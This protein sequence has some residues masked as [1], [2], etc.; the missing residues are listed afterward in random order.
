[1]ALRCGIVG[2][3]N[4]GKSTLFNCISSGKAQSANF[5]FCTIEPNIGSTIVP[6]DRLEVLEKIVKPNR[7]VPAT[8][9]IVDIAGLVK[10]ASK[11]EGLGNQFLAN[12][13][14]T[15]AILHVLRC[16][17]D[18]N[19]V[20]VDGKI[21]PASDIDTIN[22]ELL[23]SDMELLERR[24]QKTAKMAKADKQMQGE[25]DLLNRLNEFLGE[26][27]N[28]RAME[29]D[30]E[31]AAFVKSLDLLSYKPII[32]VA[33]V[34]DEDLVAGGDN[35]FVQQ[36]REIAAA[37]DAEVVVIS[38]EIESEVAEL[39]D[40]EKA[41]FLEELGI[42]ES[43]LD[44]LIAA[45][46]RTLGLHSFLTSGAESDMGIAEPV[47]E[48]TGISQ[49]RLCHDFQPGTTFEGQKI[50]AEIGVGIVI[51]GIVYALIAAEVVAFSPVKR[52]ITNTVPPAAARFVAI[53]VRYRSVLPEILGNAITP[54]VRTP[55]KI[56]AAKPIHKFP[57]IPETTTPASAAT[58]IIPSKAMF[59]I[60]ALA[61]ITAARPA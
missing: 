52:Y 8:V 29:L 30:E 6:D 59:I 35:E 51:D 39:E 18:P 11:G 61:L 2:L 33:N 46:Y 7:V 54:P 19:I 3:P 32:Y 57:V 50:G 58:S 55:N 42:E 49:I 1:M 28:A 21:N 34:S 38:A 26:G 53:Q 37:E 20:H 41:L 45:S 5:P 9:E 47:Q 15:D 36:V 4:V 22:T 43:G 24:I 13:R 40:E 12:I 17:D 25:L 31:E 60:P 27:N 16:F 56:A 44:K 23:L 10:G 48:I 14:E